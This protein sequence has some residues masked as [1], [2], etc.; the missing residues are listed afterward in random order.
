MEGMK[1]ACFVWKEKSYVMMMMLLWWWWCCVCVPNL[2]CSTFFAVALLDGWVWG[3][4]L[5]VYWRY[6]CMLILL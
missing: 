5:S 3:S 1:G 4:W 6:A 2:F